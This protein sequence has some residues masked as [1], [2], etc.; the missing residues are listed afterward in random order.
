MLV[1]IIDDNE[2]SQNF[3]VKIL[4]HHLID[5]MAFCNSIEAL[6]Y[7]TCH[8]PDVVLIDYVLPGGPNGLKLAA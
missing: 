1:V 4:R 8:E 2:T 3:A 6:N 5:V 7:L